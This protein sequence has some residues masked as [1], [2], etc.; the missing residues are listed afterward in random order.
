M[1]QNCGGVDARASTLF[2]KFAKT[3][4]A[5]VKKCMAGINFYKCISNIMQAIR[6]EIGDMKKRGKNLFRA[7]VG[8]KSEL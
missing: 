6:V 4:H 5:L 8:A 2:A 1:E 3:K 7:A